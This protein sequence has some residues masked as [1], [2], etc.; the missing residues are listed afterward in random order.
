MMVFSAIEKTLPC[1]VN[2]YIA[3]YGNHNRDDAAHMFPFSTLRLISR[4]RELDL[5]PSSGVS[6]GETRRE[7][8][9]KGWMELMAFQAIHKFLC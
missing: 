1:K 4:C 5:F 8:R 2:Y 7:Y 3:S 9:L 6:R